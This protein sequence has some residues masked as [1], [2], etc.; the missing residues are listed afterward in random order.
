[1]SDTPEEKQPAP[2]PKSWDAYAAVVAS[3]I[4]LLALLVSAY[5]ANIQRQQVRAQVWPRLEVSRA[6]D[7]R[8]I[9][10]SNV[11]IGPA[12]VRAVRVTLDGHPVKAW[13]DLMSALGHPSDYGVSQVSA[14]VLAPGQRVEAINAWDT[15]GGR[16]AFQHVFRES[17]AR[18][19]ILICYCSVLDQCW[20]AGGFKSWGIDADR[21]VDDCPIAA[22]ERFE[23]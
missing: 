11:G 16:R 14:R 23:Q 3:L 22:A 1:M 7:K 8:E 12:R 18:L 4:G 19:D 13:R 10:V 20:M 5:T 17:E 2:A 6:G 15:D 21:E 9:V